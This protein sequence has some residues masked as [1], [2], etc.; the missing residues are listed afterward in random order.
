MNLDCPQR[1][2]HSYSSMY[3]FFF[4]TN[5]A[6]AF[7][8]IVISSG[9]VILNIPIGQESKTWDRRGMYLQ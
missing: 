9:D 2:M 5:P 8:L 3:I 7:D 6:L 4:L 1:R